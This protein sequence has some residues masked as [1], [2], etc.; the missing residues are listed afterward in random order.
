MDLG[1]NKA[2]C[3][4]N[5]T[6]RTNATV[7]SDT[8]MYCDSPPILDELGYSTLHGDDL[9]FYNLQVTIDGGIVVAGGPVKFDYYQ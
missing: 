8:L 3:V 2:M 5:N 9:K 1:R 4:F 6:K 7:M